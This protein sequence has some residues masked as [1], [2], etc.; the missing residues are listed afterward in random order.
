MATAGLLAGRTHE[1]GMLQRFLDDLRTGSR[2]VVLEGEVGIGK[3]TLLDRV[4]ASA[5]ERSWPVLTSRPVESELPWEFAALADLFGGLPPD[6]VERLPPAQRR[7]LGVAVFRDEAPENSVDPLTLATAVR[8]ALGMLTEVSPVVLAVDDLPWLDPPSSRI[9]EFVL[10]RAGDAPIGMIATVRTAWETHPAAMF[11][12]DL[13]PDRVD[14]LTVGRLGAEAITQLLA[15]RDP[16]IVS[17]T[18]KLR[19]IRRWSDGNPLVALQLLRVAPGEFGPESVPDLGVPH[20]LRRL[21]DE[22][23]RSL[24]PETR[25]VLLVAALSNAPSVTRTMAAA[26]DPATARGALHDAVEAGIVSMRNDAIVFAHPLIRAVVIDDATPTER[27]QAHRRSADGA[28]SPEERARHLAL[29]SEGPDESVASEVE[30]AAEL[31][32]GRGAPE[33]AAGLAALAAELTPVGEGPAHRRRSGREADLRFLTADPPRACALLEGVVADSP[34][35][36]ERA[37]YLRRLAR[38]ATHRGDPATEWVGRL[39]SAFEEAGDDPRLRGAIALDLAVALSNAGDQARAAEFGDIA[40]AMAIESGDAARECQIYAGMAYST[41]LAG[42]G[43]VSGLVDQ[44]LSG[45]DQPSG[46]SMELRPRYVAA[47]LL[48][49]VEEY[50]RSRELFDAELTRAHDEGI[51]SGLAL[52]LGNFADLEIWTGNWERAGRLL[53]E[54]DE[55]GDESPV[56]AVVRGVRGLLQV[57][58]G[59][60]EEG[61]RCI[62]TAIRTAAGANMPILVLDNAYALGVAWAL[63]DP[64]DSHERLAPFVTMARGAGVTEPSLLRFVP[65]EI[66]ALVRLHEL[67]AAAEL[68]TYFEHCAAG[69]TRC[70]DSAAAARCRGLL[71][72]ARGDVEEASSSIER[73]IG[74]HQ[75]VRQPFEEARTWLIAGEIHRRA[76]AKRKARESFAHAVGLFDKLGSPR[77]AQRARDEMGRVGVRAGG[78]TEA[79]AELT[80]AEREVV[81]LVISGLSNRQVAEQLFMGQRTVESHLTRAYR[82]LGVR[83][84]TQLAPAYSPGQGTVD[85][86]PPAV[87]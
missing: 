40:L 68:L 14:R 79:G 61:R 4:V 53:D 82:K 44:A 12:D 42:G 43:S 8:S 85:P 66:S 87:E 54:L 26:R 1:V 55:N 37:E 3:S 20:A 11:T 84:R 25:D 30:H 24:T 58:Q 46:L 15:D 49:Y 56:V 72:I 47:R 34:R 2:V 13:E 36:P 77:W 70:W 28:T 31:A 9:L 83:S 74:F 6:V 81:E 75:R 23:L 63:G 17:E 27:R 39:A 78:P 18:T 5:R 35:G 38:Y 45:P 59:R 10:R 51:T 64:S 65:D 52:L 16:T 41:F 86:E 71:A 73:A 32:A 76:R 33:T 29:G 60:E 80:V 69:S 19:E 67:E 48:F 62:D 21:I 22:R 57:C 7:A 50:R